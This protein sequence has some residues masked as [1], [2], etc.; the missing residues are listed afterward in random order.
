MTLLGVGF[1][2]PACDE[3]EFVFP[4]SIETEEDT[5]EESGP[6]PEVWEV[7]EDPEGKFAS[8]ESDAYRSWEANIE[9]LNRSTEGGYVKMFA[10]LIGDVQG[11]PLIINEFYMEK[12]EKKIINNKWVARGNP[13]LRIWFESENG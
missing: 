11:E 9:V 1:L 7:V 10:Q 6:K 8:S 12:G 2:F 5:D 3:I 13:R 4:D